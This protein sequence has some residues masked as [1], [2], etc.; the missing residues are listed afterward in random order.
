MVTSRGVDNQ[1][2]HSL[3][4]PLIAEWRPLPVLVRLKHEVIP[5]ARQFIRRLFHVEHLFP[6]TTFGEH[7]QRLRHKHPNPRLLVKKEGSRLLQ[8]LLEDAPDVVS[9][10]HNIIYRLDD[11]VLIILLE[12]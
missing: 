1:R 3:V 5:R 11:R 4:D 7:L 2:V 12:P 9:W 6:R 8:V 10:P